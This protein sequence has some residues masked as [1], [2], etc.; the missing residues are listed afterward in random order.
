MSNFA[1]SATP[2][3]ANS[4]QA[5][6]I[7]ELAIAKITKDATFTAIIAFNIVL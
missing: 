2:T 4:R 3:A 6:I 1:L 7:G 5:R